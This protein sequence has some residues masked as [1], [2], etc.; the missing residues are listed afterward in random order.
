MRIISR[1]S[2]ILT[3]GLSK[4]VYDL[5]AIINLSVWWNFGSLL[6]LCLV[7]QIV[8]GIF[9]AM[10][11]TPHV[12]L[13]FSSVVHVMRDVN[14]GWLI[15]GVHANGASFFFVCIYAHIGRGIYYGSYMLH[16]VWFRGILLL[17]M[18]MATAFL[19]YV[20]PWG[21]IS[22]WG[23]TVIT[24]LVTVIP[25]VG[26]SVLY[27]LWGGHTIGSATLRRFYAIHFL[28]PFVMVVA[29]LIHIRFLHEVGRNNPLGFEVGG[30][31]VP[32][33]VY[34]TIKDVVGFVV[35]TGFLGYVCLLNPDL[36]LDA[37][38]FNP[39]N[40][41]STPVHIQPEWYFLF[42]YAILRSIPNKTGG[43]VALVGAVLVPVVLPLFTWGYRGPVRAGMNPLSGLLF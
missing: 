37:E 31:K 32:F 20:L 11:Y 9:L 40:P 30:E 28:L 8:R 18:L 3:G 2:G 12:D 34:Y 36:F 19:G 25:Y 43:V 1:K 6:G 7:I 41:L 13:A 4:V 22:Y 16:K 15:R 14:S 35:M 10:H 39:A 26:K 38:N 21:Q 23:A 17:F 27:W 42:A 24:N 29:V 33:H 5:P